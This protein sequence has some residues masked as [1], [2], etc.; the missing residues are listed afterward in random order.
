MKEVHGQL[1]HTF[2]SLYTDLRLCVKLNN[3]VT[4]FFS[5]NIDTH[6]R[7]KQVRHILS[8]HIFKYELYDLLREN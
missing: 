3:S 5:C 2:K 6:Q 1:M 8:L 4:D 7:R